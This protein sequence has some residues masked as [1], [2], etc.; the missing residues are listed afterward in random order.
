MFQTLDVMISLGV[1]FLILSMVHKYIMSMVKRL[2]KVKATVI[3]EE[4]KTFVG[5]NTSR[6]LI[7]YLR[8]KAKYL[9]FLDATKTGIAIWKG[10]G[11]GLRH[12]NKEQLTNVIRDFKEFLTKEENPSKELD[13]TDPNVSIGAT[14]IENEIKEI[15]I[16][17]LETLSGKMEKMYD[18]TTNKISEVYKLKMRYFTMVFGVL[19]AVFINADFFEIYGSLSTNALSRGKIV[20]QSEMITTKVSNINAKLESRGDAVELEKEIQEAKEDITGLTEGL[21]E[22]GVLLGWNKTSINN[23]FNGLGSF[24]NKLIGLAISGLLISFGAPFWHDFL[25]SF[26]GMK[27]AA[28]GAGY[29]RAG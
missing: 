6:Y 27:R 17:H 1:V 20:V 28:R 3:A 25:G 19:L 12:L 10:D 26:V 29:G 14:D 13:V 24:L 23:A 4:M 8:N 9:N 16:P 2:L 11:E 5:E 15:I 21:K 18:N 7:P 22:A